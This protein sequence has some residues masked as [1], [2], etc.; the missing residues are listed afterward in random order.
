[1]MVSVKKSLIGDLLEAIVIASPTVG[2]VCQRVG[3]AFSRI[4]IAFPRVGLLCIP[5]AIAY[6]AVSCS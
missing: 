2:S 5:V 1:M 3:L 6:T 4:G